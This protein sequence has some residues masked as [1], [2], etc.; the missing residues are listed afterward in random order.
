MFKIAW[1]TVV[2]KMTLRARMKKYVVHMGLSI[3]VPLLFTLLSIA[4][5]GSREH[6]IGIGIALA[7]LS[8]N[9]FYSFYFLKSSI[10]INSISGIVITITSIGFTWL[11]AL[12]EIKPSCDFYGIYTLLFSYGIFSILS[13]E[14][15][16]Q[17]LQRR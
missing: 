11:V 15:T 12:S 5:A 4:I 3:V 17:L 13:W 10:L 14:G 16:Y 1:S 8:L 9:V 2:K 7:F 6:G